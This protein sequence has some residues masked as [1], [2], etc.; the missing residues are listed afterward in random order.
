MNIEKDM[1]G[2]SQLANGNSLV[3]NEL[4]TE[5][6]ALLFVEDRSL[7]AVMPSLVP[8]RRATRTTMEHQRIAERAYERFQ[9]RGRIHGHDLEDW[10]AA[11]RLVL[12][13]LECRKKDKDNRSK[14]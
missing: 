14:I 4:D 8:P 7:R 13:S 6:S 5:D 12:N 2:E 11:E 1:G 10:L 3:E 9:A